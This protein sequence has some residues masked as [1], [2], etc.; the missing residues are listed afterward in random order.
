QMFPLRPAPTALFF[1]GA[2][3]GAL[4]H[5]TIGEGVGRIDG[6]I[7]D[8]SGLASGLATTNTVI[9][10]VMSL[11]AVVEPLGVMADPAGGYERGPF[12]FGVGL[13]AMY[14][15]ET[16]YD[17]TGYA[18]THAR[19]L[20]LDGAVRVGYKGLFLQ[21]E[22]LFRR[23]VDDLTLRPMMTTGTYGEVSYFVLA[24]K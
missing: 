5:L 15:I 17:E 22:L 19:D 23:Q 8:G 20:R 2:D 4:A 11:S 21:G 1:V 6:G 7:F 10:P 9:G 3:N 14:R 13:G 18:S 16:V 24:S 12:R